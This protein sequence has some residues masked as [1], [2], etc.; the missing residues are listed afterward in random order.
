[1]KH[2]N[3]E[4]DD[5]VGTITIDRTDRFNSLDVATAQDLRKAGLQLA[6]DD[7]VRVV[8][9]RGVGGIFCSGADLKYISTDEKS[10][11]CA[12]FSSGLLRVLLLARG[13]RSGGTVVAQRP[14]ACIWSVRPFLM[15]R[16]VSWRRDQRRRWG[17]VECLGVG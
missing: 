7:G 17:R 4:R 6:R 10:R 14:E 15:R 2:M 12:N 5:G 3:V 9:I 8:V 1:M 13:V 11:A 16:G